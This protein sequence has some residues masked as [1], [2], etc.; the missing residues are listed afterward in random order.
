[1]ADPPM[2]LALIVADAGWFNTENLFRETDVESVSVLLYKCMD[3]WN[4]FRR[5]IHPWSRACRTQRIG[6]RLWH[7]QHVLPSGWMKRFPRL[8]MRPIAR[9]ARR[10]RDGLPGPTRTA[11]VMSYPYYLTLRDLL[12]PDVLVYY[13][14]DDYSLYWPRE[15][16]RTAELER[17]AVRESD[18]TICVSRLRTHELQA[19]VP[20]AADRIHHIPHG[21]PSHFL[22]D[23]PLVAPEPAPADLAAL[24]RPLLGYIG[25][26]EDRVDWALMDALA[27][28]FPD[29]SFV[30][31]GRRRPPGDEPWQADCERFLAR[32]NVHCAGWRTQEQLPAYLRAFDVNLIPYKID[33][34]FNRV[35]N[36][37][38]I[39]DAMAASRPMVSTAIPECLLHRGRFHVAASQGEFIAAVGSILESGSDDG[40]AAARLEYAADHS[41]KRVADRI[42]SLV[43]EAGRFPMARA[44][45]AR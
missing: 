35:C 34:A 37:T 26:L 27:R 11:L 14:I 5:G 40:R 6:P 30:V 8:G 38:K 44:T 31:V 2:D 41:C 23:R 18:L 21:A 19:A 12:R 39:M 33:H 45:P 25:S 3:Y 17:K 24:P 1:M 22:A 28:E 36:P 32:P 15:A 16:E 29:A 43:M 4:G 9:S 20:E 42:T 10:W 13:N 7:C